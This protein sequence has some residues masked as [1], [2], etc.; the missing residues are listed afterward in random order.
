MSD[1]YSVR[2]YG[3]QEKVFELVTSLKNLV[4]V[5]DLLQKSEDVEVFN[6]SFHG[7]MMMPRNFGWDDHL[8]KWQVSS[9]VNL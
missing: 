6:V 3:K 8:P 7:A 2:I 4:Y 5:V 1:L 9:G